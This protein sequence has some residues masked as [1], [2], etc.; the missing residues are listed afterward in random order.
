ME[1]VSEQNIASKRIN[2]GN[3]TTV[4]HFDYNGHHQIEST[5]LEQKKK[6]CVNS[7][8]YEWRY[9]QI[10]FLHYLWMSFG[11]QKESWWKQKSCNQS[12]TT[13]SFNTIS[14]LLPTRSKRQ[15]NDIREATYIIEIR[16]QGFPTLV[17]FIRSGPSIPT[18]GV[19]L[20]GFLKA[21]FS[22]LRIGIEKDV[23]SISLYGLTCAVLLYKD[24]KHIYSTSVC[25]SSHVE[26]SAD[27]YS[28]SSRT[29]S[30]S[31]DRTWLVL[32]R[33]RCILLRVTSFS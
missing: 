23:S 15:T 26:S 8:L 17:I 32:I 20:H 25:F 24:T 6:T 4:C 21:K 29:F 14:T 11:W 10:D 1:H 22:N 3:I 2:T 5:C 13:L 27:L 30:K 16:V 12:D 7:C 31:T 33:L 19:C 9:P 18:T 28:A